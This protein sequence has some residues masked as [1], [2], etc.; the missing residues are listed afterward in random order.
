MN[1]N[2]RSGTP[3]L[4]VEEL[5]V[6]YTGRAGGGLAVDG[7]SFELFKSETLGIVG[8]SGSGKTALAMAIL[9]L[10]RSPGEIVGGRVNF[11]GA[12]LLKLDE[13]AMR[14]VR[15]RR[16]AVILQDP[17]TSLN[18]YMSVGRQ[19]AEVTR[20]HLGFTR[21]E[22][23]TY[24][25]QML[26]RVGIADAPR[27]SRQYPHE[28][29]GGMRQRV[30]IAMAI[31]CRPEIIIA[32]EPTTALDAT[33]QAQ[34]LELLAEIQAS[35]GTS[36]ILI[37]HDLGVI[38]NSAD[39]VIVMYAG[40]AFEVG[41]S[42]DVFSRTANPY[43]R[44]LIASSPGRA[45]SSGD[46]LYQIP[47]LPPDIRS[48]R[49]ACAFAPRCYRAEDICGSTPPPLAEPEPRHFSRCHF[50]AETLASSENL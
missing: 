17:M 31:S 20:A 6:A 12:D 18:P 9:R 38:A 16:I 10:I 29:S 4:A 1:P 5:K 35:L 50:A 44:S 23:E 24:A 27:S 2:I 26:D 34:V 40:K 46:E 47:G 43:T 32:D 22:A 11:D 33:I 15:G 7:V 42:D 41:A 14:G 49:D 28:F 13:R 37:S 48:I 45:L 39:R 8:E 3:L 25:I 19:L 21:H 36:I 30:M